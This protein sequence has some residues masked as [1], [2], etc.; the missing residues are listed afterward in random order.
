MLTGV[1]RKEN[2]MTSSVEAASR[3]GREVARGI[4]EG[5]A[6]MFKVFLAANTE[7]MAKYEVKSGKEVHKVE[8]RNSYMIFYNFI[9]FHPYFH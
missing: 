7:Y 1:V 4:M 8:V 6:E 9:N 2:A 5:S 3:F